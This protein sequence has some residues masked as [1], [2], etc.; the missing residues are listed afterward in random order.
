MITSV[1]TLFNMLQI[2][3]L[4]LYNHIA[5]LLNQGS[6]RL[7]ILLKLADN[8]NTGNILQF[9]FHSLHRNML[10]LHFLKNTAHALNPALHLLNRAVNI[11][12]FT[13]INNVIEFHFQLSHS[14]FIRAQNASP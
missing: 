7:Y 9:F 12:L 14:Q 2:I 4:T 10:A 8:P 3:L 1:T 6:N 11:I 13:F 5:S